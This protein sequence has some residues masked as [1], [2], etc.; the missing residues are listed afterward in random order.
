LSDQCRRLARRAT[1]G[2]ARAGGTGSNGSGD[3]FLAF[4][5]GNSLAAGQSA[6]YELAMVPHEMLNDL[7]VA[8]ADATEEAI[9][10]SLCAAETMTGFRGRTAHAM[11]LDLMVDIVR[12]QRG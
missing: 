6:P 10:N 11:P 3:I 7:F 2:L 8:V 4:A 12:S 5:T 1:V 9:L